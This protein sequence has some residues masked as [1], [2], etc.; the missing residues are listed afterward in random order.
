MLTVVLCLPAAG[1]EGKCSTFLRVR[2]SIDLTYFDYGRLAR[3]VGLVVGALFEVLHVRAL[4]LALVVALEAEEVV[5][6]DCGR[7]CVK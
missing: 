6:R 3:V 4:V 1:S 7:L 5:V 2:H